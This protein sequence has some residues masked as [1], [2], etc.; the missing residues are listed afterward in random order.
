[1]STRD[2][3]ELLQARWAEGKFLCLGLDIDIK[4]IPDYL[5]PGY[6]LAG[7]LFHF[8]RDII[9]RTHYLVA[10]YKPN[11]AFYEAYGPDGLL[12]LRDIVSYI[13]KV[14][15]GVVVLIDGKRADIG[16]TNLFTAVGLFDQF[17][18][19]AIT[20][21]P[22]LGFVDGIEKLFE[23]PD[24][25]VFV[26]CKTSNKGSAEFQD[27]MVEVPQTEAERERREPVARLPLY[28]Y[29]ARRVTNNWNLHENAG[30]VVGA[31]Y[32]EQLLRVRRQDIA[33]HIPILIPGVGTQGGDLELAVQ[34]GRNKERT[35]ILINSSSSILYA[36][37]GT[38]FAEAAL[39][40]TIDLDNAIRAID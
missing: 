38:D 10:C 3:S 35:G 22:Y 40:K 26:L 4:R 29:V 31:T 2:F 30:L 25:G 37:S 12:A 23:R 24:K 16:N 8:A 13:H 21:N 19:D 6:S 32:P 17:G 20:A 1:M 14:A 36:S 11:F 5:K 15:P 33:P 34:N 28:Q 7:A 9:D 39:A 18:A 27:L